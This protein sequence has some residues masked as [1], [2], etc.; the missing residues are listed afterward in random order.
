MEQRRNQLLAKLEH[1]NEERKAESSQKGDGREVDDLM[2]EIRRDLEE[3]K[4][5]DAKIERLQEFLAFSTNARQ[6]KSIQNLL[7]D[8][9]KFK[10]TQNSSAK[11]KFTGFSFKKTTAPATSKPTVPAQNLEKSEIPSV[12]TTAVE[13]GTLLI[14]LSSENKIIDGKDGEDISL[15]NVENCRLL[16]NFNPSIV[17]LRNVKN[18][19]LLFLRCE[20]SVLMND[21]ENLKIYVAAQQVRIHT[22]HHIHL[23]V[24][25]RGAV[26]LEDS[27]SIFMYPYRLKNAENSEF[28]PVE[29][30][31][32]WQTPR[33]FNWLATSQSPNWKLMAEDEWD[34]EERF[35]L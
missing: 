20:Q 2:D 30:N 6:L 23:H 27:S 14:D 29:D 32:E 8:V 12:S 11:P 9:R 4:V 16:F 21:C 10:L 34:D 3:K 31:L 28:L 19:T 33:D 17:H 18:S 1:R 22:S 15:K 5:E 7:E 13:T 26:I 24:A 35:S 25:T